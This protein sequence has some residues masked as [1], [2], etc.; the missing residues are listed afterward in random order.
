MA[1]YPFEDWQRLVGSVV[2]VRRGRKLIRTGV[3]DAAMPDSS[4]LWL[5]ASATDSRT[6]YERSL[7][8]SV[9]IEPRQLAE[10]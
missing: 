10:L 8:Y 3:V 5:S 4:A 7:G 2:E 1:S 9:W 6:L